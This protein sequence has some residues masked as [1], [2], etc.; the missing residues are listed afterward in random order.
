MV[1]H[2]RIHVLFEMVYLLT[3]LHPVPYADEG[4]LHC[5]LSIGNGLLNWLQN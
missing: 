1:T 4:I 2:R 3:I 5:I